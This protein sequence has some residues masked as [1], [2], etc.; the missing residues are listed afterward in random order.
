M[1]HHSSAHVRDILNGQILLEIA[2]AQNRSPPT[3]TEIRNDD[4]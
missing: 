2:M 3:P 4:Q 1:Q